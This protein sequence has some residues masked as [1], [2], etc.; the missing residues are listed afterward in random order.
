[1]T[2]ENFDFKVHVYKTPKAGYGVRTDQYI[3]SG[4]TFFILYYI[5]TIT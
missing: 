1:M 5:L 4:K 3:Q 2:R